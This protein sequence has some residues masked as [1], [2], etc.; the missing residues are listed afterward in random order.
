MSPKEPTGP[1]AGR[2]GY[3][4][5]RE[6]GTALVRS[7]DEARDG[8]AR[9]RRGRRRGWSGAQPVG[10]S[11]TLGNIRRSPLRRVADGRRE[12]HPLPPRRPRAVEVTGVLDRRRFGPALDSRRRARGNR[13]PPGRNVRQFS[14]RTAHRGP[15]FKLPPAGRRWG[16]P[17]THARR[18]PARHWM[19]GRWPS[20]RDQCKSVLRC[21][22]SGQSEYAISS[23][24]GE[25]ESPGA[26]APTS[27]R[28]PL[29]AGKALMPAR[30]VDVHRRSPVA[31]LKPKTRPS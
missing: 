31:V 15:V 27:S 17:G 24:T 2:P 18:P 14:R 10:P 9:G 30:A 21:E 11:V 3:T 22:R 1:G 5:R 28:L 23:G 19:P 7:G 20:S 13:H 6:K 16:G 4:A 29:T 26:P 8:A 12:G 25:P